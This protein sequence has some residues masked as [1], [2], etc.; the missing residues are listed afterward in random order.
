MLGLASVLGSDGATAAVSAPMKQLY[1]A[2]RSVH[3]LVAASAS[4]SAEQLWQAS[5]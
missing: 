1:L 4:R 3:E 2:E 5:K